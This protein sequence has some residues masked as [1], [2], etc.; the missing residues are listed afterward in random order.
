MLDW[1]ARINIYVLSRPLALGVGVASFI[2]VVAADYLTT[3]E[4]S[5][6]PF[7]LF[8]VL[9][10]TWNCGWKWGLLFAAMSFAVPIVI[11][12][13][14]GYVYSEPIYF[15][16]DNANRLVSYLVALVLASQLKILHEREKES[17]RLDYLTGI[18]NQKGF[19]EALGVEIARHRRE[20]IPLAVAYLDCDN[21]KDVNNRFG[22]REGD[23]LLQGVA[24]TLKDNL[25]KTDV[26]G[27]LGGDEFA[28]VLVNTDKSHAVDAVDKLT[29][30]LD[31]TM[32]RHGWPVTFSIGLGIFTHVPATDDEIISFTDKLMYRVKA[33]GKN[34]VL[35]EVF[36]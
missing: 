21:F 1:L 19:Y 3:Y 6:T 4:L 18:A 26:I 10:V 29:F 15:Y 16:I 25:R 17:A 13:Q 2:L 36:A 11:G 24:K 20:K 32:Q 5:L 22:H 30:E 34:N 7:Y 28:I 23:R 27:R 31:A 14:L 12:N 8:V 9:L 33:S 35:T